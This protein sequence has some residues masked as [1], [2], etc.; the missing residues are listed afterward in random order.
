[1]VMGES[2]AWSWVARGCEEISFFVRFRY[3]FMA[4]SKISWKLEDDE[5]RSEM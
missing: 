3:M 4:L 1:M 2:Q 5:V